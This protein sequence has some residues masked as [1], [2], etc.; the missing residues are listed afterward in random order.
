MDNL[1]SEITDEYMSVKKMTLK[2]SSLAQYWS[3]FRLYLLPEFGHLSVSEIGRSDVIA[4]VN[5]ISGITGNTIMSVVRL[6]KNVLNYARIERNCKIP[7]LSGIYVRR[8]KPCPRVL[9]MKEQDRLT[10]HLMSNS[11]I[12]NESMLLCLYTGLRIGEICA[13]KWG[14]ISLLEK[15]V[16]V[17][18][19]LQRVCIN[20]KDRQG[21][22]KTKIL[23]DKPKSLESIRT[24]P[25]PSKLIPRLQN[26]QSEKSFY[27][28]TGNAKYMEP[29][30]L[31]NH[32]YKAYR[33]CDIDMASYHTLR[34][35]YA[36]RCIELGMDIRTLSEL[37]GHSSIS[38][39][40]QTYM[41]ST[42]AH[43]ESVCE[44][45]NELIDKS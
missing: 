25:I 6:L 28:L 21:V 27:V 38:I 34:H 30:T 44:L 41:H 23:I 5:S 15:H 29:R 36:T 10:K 45:Q 42:M 19:T 39:T 1:F 4:F 7:D 22:R 2:E 18:K 37:L 17:Y 20:D 14:D 13:L 16:Y 12:T 26:I 24:I 9:T 3:M 11:S 31:E 33:L 43:K 40:L 32:M 35:S 8:T